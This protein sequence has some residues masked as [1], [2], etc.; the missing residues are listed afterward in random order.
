MS[1]TEVSQEYEKGLVSVI[2]ATYNRGSLINEAI[3]S[4][5]NQTYKNF[6]LI[7]VDDGSTDD[8]EMRVKEF[9]NPRIRYIFQENHGRS[10][11][12]NTAIKMSTGEYLTFLDDDD[13][14]LANKI[15]LQVEFM[16]NNS[17]CDVVYSEALCFITDKDKTFMK[18]SAKF[19]G[20]IYSKIALYIPHPICLP[21]I[22]LRRNVVIEIGLFDENLNRFEDVDLWRRIS[23]KYPYFAIQQPLCLLRT[24]QENTIEKLNLKNL[25][26]QVTTYVKKVLNEDLDFYGDK[27][28]GLCADLMKHYA[29]AIMNQKT[30]FLIGAHLY[31]QALLLL[32]SSSFLSHFRSRKTQNSIYRENSLRNNIPWN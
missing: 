21:T 17:Q 3:D 8:T 22:M 14:Y 2:I 28:T 30:G 1:L 5:L 16:K 24:H 29:R 7:I 11:A 9:N 20:N 26:N 12:R 27:L 19:E 13:L 25:S 4:V 10:Y 18:Y 23:K 15:E 31:L 32:Q 6:E